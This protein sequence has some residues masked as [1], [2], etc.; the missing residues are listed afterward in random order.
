MTSGWD[1]FAEEAVEG[2]VDDP[3][4]AEREEGSGRDEAD[5]HADRLG[6]VEEVERNAEES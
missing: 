5:A 3:E 1:E 6:R 2:S 4:A